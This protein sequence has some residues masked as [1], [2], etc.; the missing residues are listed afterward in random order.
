[1]RSLSPSQQPQSMGKKGEEEFDP[2]SYHG[3]GTGT[4]I[5]LSHVSRPLL[6]KDTL[7]RY[8]KPHRRILDQITRYSSPSILFEDSPSPPSFRTYSAQMSHQSRLKPHVH[9]SSVS[10]Q[11]SLSAS[12]KQTYMNLEDALNASISHN[13][14]DDYPE[15]DMAK[16]RHS[17]SSISREGKREIFDGARQPSSKKLKLSASSTSTSS[18]GPSSTSMIPKHNPTTTKSLHPCEAIL[19]KE[20]TNDG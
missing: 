19:A 9:A 11:Y 18:H 3:Q 16:A 15:S 12:R 13:A 6:P 14:K 1:M 7:A 4:N 2:S 8:F 17:L 5:F 10:E 20:S